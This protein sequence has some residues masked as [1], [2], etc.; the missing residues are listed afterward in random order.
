MKPLVN[1]LIAVIVGK[2]GLEGAVTILGT[3]AYLEDGTVDLANSIYIDW[4]A[5][6]SSI[7]NFLIIAFALFMIIKIING[8]AEAQARALE[9]LELNE[10]KAIARIRREQK[11]SMKQARAIYEAK[12]AELKAKK[13]AEDEEAAAKAAAEAK[14]A[15]EK[16]MANTRLLEEIRDLLKKQA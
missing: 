4:G 13:Q 9:G 12:E 5:F 2:N 3:P 16:A 14:A 8:V 11:V 6:V 7:I 10:K 15:E 1:W